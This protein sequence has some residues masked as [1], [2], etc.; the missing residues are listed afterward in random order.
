V[1]RR[2]S[3]VLSLLLLASV[4]GAQEPSLPTDAE[5]RSAYCISVLQW[6]I[7]NTS[8]MVAALANGKTAEG[9]HAYADSQRSVEKFQSALARLQSYLLPRMPHL[10]PMPLALAQKRGEA[11]LQQLMNTSQCLLDC[12][13]KKGDNSDVA[14]SDSCTDKPLVQRMRACAEPSW[15]PF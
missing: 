4:S 12:K 8:K 9:Q 10:D 15:L 11:D 14:C 2:L 13:A 1:A 7:A 5:L 3:L 6:E